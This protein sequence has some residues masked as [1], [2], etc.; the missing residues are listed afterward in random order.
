MTFYHII[1]NLVTAKPQF[2]RGGSI[3]GEH[4]F[5]SEEHL[6]ITVT[7][8]LGERRGAAGGALS[9]GDADRDGVQ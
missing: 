9:S 1:V 2:M 7:E 8:E 4:P 6:S 3:G 5:S